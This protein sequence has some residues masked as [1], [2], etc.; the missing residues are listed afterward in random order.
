MLYVKE[1]HIEVDGDAVECHTEL[2]CLASAL[3][4]AGEI[5]PSEFLFMSAMEM[6]RFERKMEKEGYDCYG[7]REE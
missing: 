3:A 4:K 2:M 6:D 5:K 1:G 7:Q